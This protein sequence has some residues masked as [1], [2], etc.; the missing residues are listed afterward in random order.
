L[1]ALG[2]LRALNYLRQYLQMAFQMIVVPQQQ[3]VS[4]A[5]EAFAADG[6]LA[7][8]KAAAMLAGVVN[9]VLK[10]AASRQN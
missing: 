3:A 6:A 4:R 10:L 2:G 1:S 5:H 9:A 7:D 8:A